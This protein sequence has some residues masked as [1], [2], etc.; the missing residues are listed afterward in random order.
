MLCSGWFETSL[1]REAIET[2]EL[3]LGQL[4]RL[5]YL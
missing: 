3:T 4:N 2:L 5:S 1:P